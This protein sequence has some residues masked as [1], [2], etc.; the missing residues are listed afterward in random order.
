[1]HRTK[2]I[3]QDPDIFYLYGMK[4]LFCLLVFLSA[5]N[6]FA[7]TYG[8]LITLGNAY[9]DSGDFESSIKAFSKAIELNSGSG[10]IY[11][12]RAM[13]RMAAGDHRGAIEDF[14]QSLALGYDRPDIA[15]AQRALCKQQ[16]KDVEGA[17]A[18]FGQVLLIN[19]NDYFCFHKRGMLK[20]ETGDVA[21]ASADMEKAIEHK[22]DYIDPLVNL[23]IIKYKAQDPAAMQYFDRALRIDSTQADI[24]YYRS[25]AM[26]NLPSLYTLQDAIGEM[27]KAVRF[28]PSYF[29][30]IK[31]LGKMK[32]ETGDYTGAIADLSKAISLNSHDAEIYNDRGFLYITILNDKKAAF[33]DFNKSVESDPFYAEAYFN[34]GL[35]KLLLDQKGC[36]DLK[37]AQ[38]LNHPKAASV[39]KEY[40]H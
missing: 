6:G 25:Y 36:P 16:L 30:A 33:Q 39:L 19:P 10:S 12:S 24:Y 15:Y 26:A 31:S 11:T 37:K 23:G 20:L 3:R 18:D 29:E 2:Q 40:C 34:R 14:D 35:T 22:P 21:G 8:E 17:M 38:E 27:E 1:M 5:F 4:N 32:I 13:S 9:Y 28:D 7:Q